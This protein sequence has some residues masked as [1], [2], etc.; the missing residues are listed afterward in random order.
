V[1]WIDGGRRTDLLIAVGNAQASHACW[2]TVAG[3][4]S[5]ATSERS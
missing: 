3:D 1:L 4:L 5:A 2:L